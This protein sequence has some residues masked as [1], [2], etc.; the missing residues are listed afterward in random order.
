MRDAWLRCVQNALASSNAAVRTDVVLSKFVEA[1]LETKYEL[2]PARSTPEFA[3]HPI[4]ANAQTNINHRM[5]II[6]WTHHTP[7]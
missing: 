3:A 6:F 1:R 2:L 4:S 7:A 5:R